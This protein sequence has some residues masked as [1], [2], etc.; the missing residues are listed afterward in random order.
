MS[1]PP[2]GDDGSVPSGSGW[3]VGRVVRSRVPV[4]VADVGGWTDTWFGSPGTVCPIAVG[5]PVEV[6]AEVIAREAMP[7]GHHAEAPAAPAP[8]RLV[9][10]ALGI[11]QPTGPSPTTGWADP[12]PGRH[13]LLEH[14]VGEVIE[15]TP[16]PVDLGV[17]VTITSAVPPGASLGTSASV[18]VAVLAAL[19]ALCGAA[20]AP[21][22]PS[23]VDPATR[24]S[25][26]D[27][28][29]ADLAMRAHRVETVRAGRQAGVQD[30]WI[31][32]L[33]GAVRLDVG[34]YPE[35][36]WRR[37]ALTDATVA[38]LDERLVT[39]VV[40]RHDSSAVHEE[41]IQA[42]TS[43]GG[44]DQD[45]A[46]AALRR[47][48]ALAQEAAAALEAGDLE[49]WAAAL[50]ESTATQARLHPAL[51]GPDHARAIAVA[52]DQG[53]TG[54]K[55]NGAGGA[56]GSLTVLAADRPGAADDLA[57]AL[58]STSSAWVVLRSPVSPGVQVD[59]APT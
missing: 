35:G 39:V 32:A 36:R 11:D 8:V 59:P 9:A 46:R 4:R 28:A 43:C 48:A 56:G 13:P 25:T 52:A 45:R 6:T 23:A 12:R 40:G 55:V 58:S 21:T 3:V 38:A 2:P 1:G 26:R 51:V 54:W 22:D 5:P 33:G 41:V 34:P 53:A 44:V 20:P 10:P 15:R 24:R 18:V 47:L 31:A 42:I 14:A 30:Q 19:D 16:L 17:V 57:A 37:L 7:T 27:R 49:A 50:V 29:A